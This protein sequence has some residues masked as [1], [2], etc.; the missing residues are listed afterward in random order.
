MSVNAEKIKI[1]QTLQN[2]CHH[3]VQEKNTKY[4]ELLLKILLIL[5]YIY[6][7]W[8]STHLYSD[9]AETH[10]NWIDILIF[11]PPF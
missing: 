6:P 7:T 4:Q 9:T 8:F 5:A 3:K 2:L 1:I 11:A 10:I